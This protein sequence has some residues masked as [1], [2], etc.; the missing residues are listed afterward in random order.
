MLVMGSVES[1]WFLLVTL[2]H[3]TWVT[4]V[5]ELLE[6]TVRLCHWFHFNMSNVLTQTSVAG[7]VSFVSTERDVQIYT[8]PIYRNLLCPCGHLLWLLLIFDN[9]KLCPCHVLV[10]VVYLNLRDS[11]KIRK[12]WSIVC[13]IVKLN[14]AVICWW[15]HLLGLLPNCNWEHKLPQLSLTCQ[16]R[17]RFTSLDDICSLFY[18]HKVIQINCNPAASK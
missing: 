7:I 10:S 1:T 15:Q 17:S 8:D 14:C 2:M 6:L 11:H 4:T 5:F 9:F 12:G 16:H 13:A 18:F 3:C